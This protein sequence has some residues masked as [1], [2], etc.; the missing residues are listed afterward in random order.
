M[1]TSSMWVLVII[2]GASLVTIGNIQYNRAR[3][4]EKTQ[5]MAEQAFLLLRPEIQNNLSLLTRMR[6]A[7][8]KKEITLEEF[9][10]T[11][12]QTV[13]NSE[14]LLGLGTGQ[15]PQIMRMYYLT[16]LANTLHSRILEMSIGV[17]SALTRAG[18]TKELL[19]NNLLSVLNE[20]EPIFTSFSNSKN[21]EKES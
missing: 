4:V 3:E 20:L 16:N 8:Q 11:A 12:W 15:L 7:I 13:S 5:T 10:S 17:T 18:K 19:L 9:D 14:L 2:V 1:A 6:T 21:A